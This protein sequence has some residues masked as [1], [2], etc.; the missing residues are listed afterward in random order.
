MAIIRCTAK[1]LRELG[2]QPANTPDQPPDLFDWHAN[3]LRLD[4][5]KHVLFTNSQTLYSLLIRWARKPR[6]G[7]FQEQFR[8]G[9]FKS[10]MSEGLA[11]SQVEY[12]MSG[13]TQV[14]IMKT[15]NRSVLGSMNELTFLIESMIPVRGKLDDADF[16]EINRELNRIPMGAIDYQYS[17]AELKRRLDG[18][19]Q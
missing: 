19:H 11:E 18:M 13:H 10:L 14:T 8:L 15:N 16:S 17:I 4:R 9:L 5:K 3:M 2:I 12:M 6:P 7:D 1:L